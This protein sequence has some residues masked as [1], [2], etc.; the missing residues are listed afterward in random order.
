MK[1]CLAAVAFLSLA[2]GTARADD[3]VPRPER[4]D[5][6][7]QVGDSAASDSSELVIPDVDEGK[8]AVDEADGAWKPTPAKTKQQDRDS[9]PAAKKTS[10]TTKA[11]TRARMSSTVTR[12]RSLDDSDTRLEKEE[13]TVLGGRHW[14]IKSGR[15]AIH[16]WVPPGYDRETAGTVVYVH[17]YWTDA[18]GAWKDYE[19]ASQFKKSRQN[20]LFIV[21]DAPANRDQGVHW[22]ALTDL[23]AAVTRANIRMPDGPIVVMGH[24][25]AFR[26]VMQW[27]D[28]RMVDQII[29]LDAMYGGEYK[30]NEFIGSGKRAD[31]HKMIVVGA[32]VA[33]ESTAFA[34]QYKFA[35]A[36]EK[37]PEM[38]SGFTV[39][40]R[41]AKL[42]YIH[43]QY[44]HYQMVR[45]KK[46]IPL[47]L[48]VTRLK[49]LGGGGKSEGSD[50]L[51]RA[52]KAAS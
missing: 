12:T 18:D 11:P 45:N 47:L 37:V 20:A 5:E 25:G 2:L 33:Q 31:E 49:A 48:K 8:P 41:R 7:P 13:N 19:L 50:M 28:H 9:E 52:I 39:G 51:S 21:P 3:P 43:S 42:L 1:L 10:T 44:D 46:V 24:S 17:G 15:G 30:F 32:S 38:M 35:M 4:S 29:L 23:R 16:V 22:P 34:K 40:E 27:V 26:T 6:T 36:R 14:R